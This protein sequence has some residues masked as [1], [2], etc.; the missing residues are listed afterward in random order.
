MM[1]GSLCSRAHIL[2]HSSLIYFTNLTTATSLNLF[3]IYFMA[4]NYLKILQMLPSGWLQHHL[5]MFACDHLG[6]LSVNQVTIVFLWKLLRLLAT[7]HSRP[8]KS[9]RANDLRNT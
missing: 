4:L 8:T 6:L 1:K 5:E 3:N 2:L 9:L 7:E